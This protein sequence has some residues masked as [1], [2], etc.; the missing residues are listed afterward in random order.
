MEVLI[1]GGYGVF[2]SRL[3]ELLTRDGCGVVIAGR[4]A[5]IARDAAAR[6]GASALRLDRSGDLAPIAEC[7][8]DVVVDAA[9]PF[10]AY[11]DD[12]YRLPRFCMARGID[13]ID[14]SDHAPFTAGIADL[15]AVARGARR[16]ALSGA[17]SVPGLSSA[18]VA[19]LAD[20]LDQIDSIETAI[21]PGNRAPRGRSVIASILG[22]AGGPMRMWKDGAWRQVRSW[23]APRRIELEPGLARTGYRI[24]VPDT[25]LFPAHFAARTV[26]F[27]AGM[28]LGVLNR[29]V[30]A[31]GT[32]RRLGLDLGGHRLGVAMS[33]WL[34]DRLSGFGTDRGGMV[35]VVT[36]RKGKESVERRWTL[37]AE[38][39]EGPFVPAIVAR[40]VI[41]AA[42][43]GGIAPGARP[44]L[45]E[46]P[47][48]D[49][50][51][52]MKDLAVTTRSQ[53][54]AAPSLFR[55]ALG[56]KWDKLD[57]VL[58]A[59][60]SGPGSDRFSGRADVERGTSVFARL[61]CWLFGFPPAGD[62]QPVTVD[63]TRSG[64][65]EVWTRHFGTATF[66]SHLTPASRPDH[67][68]RTVRA[69]HLRD[70]HP[71]REWRHAAGSAAGLVPRRAD[72]Q[73][74][75][76]D[77]RQ[78]RVRP[79][80]TIAFRCRAPCSVRSRPHRPLPRFAR[81]RTRSRSARLSIDQRHKTKNGRGLICALPLR[82]LSASP[83]HSQSHVALTRSVSSFPCRPSCARRSTASC[84]AI[85]CRPL[86]CRG[87]RIW[88][89]WP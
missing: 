68:M 82:G 48:A 86:P 38:A 71:G 2:G 7:A 35:V 45:G 89:A 31:W 41:R 4:D 63:M 72:A 58:R 36:G 1:L 26:D 19:A 32:L 34:A 75:S 16:F 53:G 5:A 52:A 67:Y 33:A 8:P 69:V 22:Q 55:D 40:A 42:R 27:R 23:S 9:G 10:G 51:T 29:A 70:R 43:R 6:I 20:D 44:C 77:K 59:A 79:R 73:T 64:D 61:T 21:L 84:R 49:I 62:G 28:E 54:H 17:S 14:L 46:I 11:G 39:G 13:Y 3:A 50:E 78:Q 47:L 87:Y 83:G 37:I 18:V 15:D 57:P 12:P 85:S 60:H 65:G 80:R 56:A 81:P 76:G 25:E 66:H 74:M 24:A 30:A 88:R